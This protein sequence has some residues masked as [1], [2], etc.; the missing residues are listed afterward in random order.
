MKKHLFIITLLAVF[1]IFSTFAQYQ[2]NC[3]SSSGET[4]TFRVVGYGKNA[5]KAS[6]N[7]ELNVIK[8]LMFEGI[9]DSQQ[10]IPMVPDTESATMKKHGKEISQLFEG[11]YKSVI[12][13]SVISRKFGKD[14][15]KQKS[16]ALDVTV[17]VRA[18][19]NKLERMGIIKKFGL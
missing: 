2:V 10:H 11:D 17:N 9:P 18:L 14:A 15:N 8:A 12:M 5:K 13:R 6:D 19:R 4:M 3:I 16:I 1:G 7:A